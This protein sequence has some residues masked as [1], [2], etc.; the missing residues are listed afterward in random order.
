MKK[1]EVLKILKDV[2]SKQKF[3]SYEVRKFCEWRNK[4]QYAFQDEEPTTF[5]KT[6]KWLKE[7]VMDNPER[8]L[9][10]IYFRGKLIGHGGL[11]TFDFDNESCEIDNLVR[12]EEEGKGIMTRFVLAM[13]KFAKDIFDAKD[14]YLR[15]LSDN[16]HAIKFYNRIGFREVEHIPL[17][18]GEYIR[19]K[20]EDTR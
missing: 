20:Y 3:N 9:Y 12:G 18:H 2:K 7:A 1:E 8:L 19:M 6:K 13:I 10:R 17:K 14:V 4:H 15:V 11:A 16:E 5:Y